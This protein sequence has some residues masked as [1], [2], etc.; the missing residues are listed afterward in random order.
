MGGSRSDA[1]WVGGRRLL[2]TV[3]EEEVR[4][5]AVVERT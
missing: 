5:E 3:E 1:T 2:L 4:A